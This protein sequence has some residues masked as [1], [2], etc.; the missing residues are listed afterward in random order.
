MQRGL[1]QTAIKWHMQTQMTQESKGQVVEV[2]VSWAPSPHKS[3]VN[4]LEEDDS[5]AIYS[6]N[7]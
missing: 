3:F 4:Q 2:K 6:H 5:L 1:V 7:Q